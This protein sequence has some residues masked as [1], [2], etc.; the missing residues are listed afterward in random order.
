MEY[1]RDLTAVVAGF[2]D[3]ASHGGAGSA[4]LAR[5]GSDAPRVYC[6]M[7]NGFKALALGLCKQRRRHNQADSAPS[8]PFQCMR[9]GNRKTPR[10]P[11]SFSMA[12]EIP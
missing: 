1:I 7:L 11:P 5:E 6:L 8:S 3:P 2:D 10:N 4:W 9:K 12:A